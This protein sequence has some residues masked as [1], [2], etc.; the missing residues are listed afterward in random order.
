MMCA[1]PVL[2]LPQHQ[3]LLKQ[4][5]LELGE[6]TSVDLQ[7]WLE[8]M[9]WT[10]FATNTVL[11][12]NT[13]TPCLLDGTFLNSIT[14]MELFW[15]LQSVWSTIGPSRPHLGMMNIA[16]QVSSVWHVTIALFYWKET[17][18]LMPPPYYIINAQFTKWFLI[19]KKTWCCCFTMKSNIG[20]LH[21]HCACKMWQKMAAAS[22]TWIFWHF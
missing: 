15:P 5:F 14:M 4:D 13:S 20:A 17:C 21:N 18:L 16:T 1:D 12:H 6:G 7:Y 11:S 10:I 3:R 8:C 22:G 2:L 9:S 19:F